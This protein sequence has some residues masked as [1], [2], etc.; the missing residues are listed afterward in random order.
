MNY[1]LV[2]DLVAAG[3]DV[4][5]VNCAHDDRP[6]WAA[7]VAHFQ[8][9]GQELQRPG[10]VL[11]DLGG[12]KLRTGAVEESARLVRWQPRRDTRGLI[13]SPGAYPG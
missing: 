5:R 4:L 8:R 13:I 2:R 1:T 6:A 3:M 9:A 11:V 7:M 12:P 10:R